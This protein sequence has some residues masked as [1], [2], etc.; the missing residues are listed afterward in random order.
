MLLDNKKIFL[1]GSTGMAGTSILR[2]LLDNAPTAAIRASY[3]NT[4]PIIKHKQVEYT[5]GDLRSLK[6]CRAMA[7]GCYCA[8]MAAAYAGGAGFMRSFPWEHMRENLIM[9]LQM[10]E[11][12]HQENV[13]RIVYIG[14]ATLYQQF[15]GNIKE[16]QLDLN[17]EPHDAYFGYGWAV[18]F[19]EKMC[20]FLNKKYGTQIAIAQ[21]ANIFGPYDKFSPDFSNFI[22][23][24]IRKAVSKMDPFEVWGTPDVTRDVVYADDFARAIVTM[25]DNE[26]IE[27]D[28]F[29]I[30]SGVKTTVGNVV[31]WALKYSGHSPSAVK[32]IQN[33]PT[34]IKFRALDCTKAKRVLRWQPQYTIEEAVK[35]TTQ[36]WL[37]NKDTW[38]K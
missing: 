6:D 22:P 13:K 24:I 9:N 15:E 26:E 32:Y 10:L 4:E 12:F 30:G 2:Y 16:E 36:W 18:R 28:I 33:K 38:K 17:K 19:V 27:F 21:T 5:R 8:I 1:A 7:A 3:H 34:T 35:K 31:E 37:E 11:A 29:N 20:K 14:S 23:A 25:A